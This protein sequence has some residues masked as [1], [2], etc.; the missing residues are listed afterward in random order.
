[1]CHPHDVIPNDVHWSAEA[2]LI[3]MEEECQVQR[4]VVGCHAVVVRKAFT[5]SA[6]MGNE[7]EVGVGGCLGDGVAFGLCLLICKYQHEGNM[8]GVPWE[9]SSEVEITMTQN[10]LEDM[11]E[12][13]DLRYHEH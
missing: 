4:F 10:M 11:S 6:K 8:E 5:E 9:P 13:E 3:P 1:M 2:I 12:G 7:I